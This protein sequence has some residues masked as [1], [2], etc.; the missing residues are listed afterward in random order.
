MRAWWGGLGGEGLVGRG[1]AVRGGWGGL[2]GGGVNVC[3]E[4]RGF[5]SH[6]FS[7][8]GYEFAKT[9]LFINT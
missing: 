4:W 5:E 6:W 9:L 1:W 7:Q 3:M 8:S 2:G